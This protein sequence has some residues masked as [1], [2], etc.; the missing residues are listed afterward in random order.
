MRRRDH[1][2]LILFLIYLGLVLWCCFGNFSDMP[3]VQKEMF[4]IPTDK[5][6]HFIMFLPF[7]FLGYMSFASRPKKRIQSILLVLA[8]LAGGVL[9]AVATE[10]GQS[11]T[12]YRTGAAFDFVADGTGLLVATVFTL[13]LV[14]FKKYQ[15]PHNAS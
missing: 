12:S 13:I 1:I 2:F 15:D 14:F 4:G 5:V 9:M 3:D 8:S 7:V 6:V 10:I 11:L